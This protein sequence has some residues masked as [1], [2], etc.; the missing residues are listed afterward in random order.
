MSISDNSSKY[1]DQQI[2][3]K[4]FD[5]AANYLATGLQSRTFWSLDSGR[6]IGLVGANS[7]GDLSTDLYG[8][9]LA[10]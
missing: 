5:E 1:S 2:I 10:W 6:F 9:G 8:Y 4:I 7:S 3:E